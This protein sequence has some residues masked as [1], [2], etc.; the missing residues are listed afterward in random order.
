M[1]GDIIIGCWVVFLLYWFVNA[2]AV[3]PTAEQQSVLSGIA[4]RTPLIIGVLFIVNRR[5]F[6]SW[7]RPLAAD[8]NRLE[9]LGA[10]L[11][12]LGLL[13]AI[14]S[15]RTLAGNWSSRVT[16]KEGHELIE[17]G[18]Y[19]FVRHPI[20]TS[21][22]LMLLGTVVGGNSLVAWFGLPFYL[23]GFWIK[24]KQEEQLLTRHFPDTYPA[25]KKRVKALIPF[26]L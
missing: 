14:W 8:A 18:P 3:K 22:L 5:L 10:A 20:Y 17:T 9:S 12:V 25:Y 4:Y 7:D 1:A 24:L 19:G 2:W 13:G 26:I 23:L 11:C 15:R 16:F 21:L 6:G